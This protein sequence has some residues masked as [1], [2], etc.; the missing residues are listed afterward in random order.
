MAKTRQKYDSQRG[1]AASRGYGRDWQRLRRLV[2]SEEPL[3]RECQKRGRVTLAVEVDHIVPIRKA[4]ER[5]LD[6]TN[7]QGLCKP[8]HSRKTARED[9]GFNGFGKHRGHSGPVG[10]DGVPMDHNHF[11]NT[12]ETPDLLDRMPLGDMFPAG[13]QPSVLP[14]TIVCGPP[15]AGKSTYIEA[16]RRPGD[17]VVDL[18]VIINEAGGGR[19]STLRQ[20]MDGLRE[21]NDRLA[22]LATYTG[23]AEAAWF[24]TLGAV[25]AISKVY[26]RVRH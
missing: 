24:C 5:R 3:C 7:L 6:Q 13:L 18:D 25:P 17:V 22:A 16:H 9:G 2:L 15:A 19:D 26:T 8:C 20:R 14:L 12:G 11:W 10:T 1:S 4:P 23:P 21:R